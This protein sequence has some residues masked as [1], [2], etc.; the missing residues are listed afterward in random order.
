MNVAAKQALEEINNRSKMT[1]GKNVIM[2][3]VAQVSAGL[4]TYF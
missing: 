3:R 4:I 1:P 2:S